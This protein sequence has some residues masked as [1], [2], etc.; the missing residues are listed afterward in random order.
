MKVLCATL[1]AIAG[2][3][4]CARP[5]VESDT[6]SDEAAI[7]ELIAQTAAA[8]NAADT[9]GWVSLFEEGAVYMPPGAPEVTTR[10]GLREM[11]A[12]GFGPYAAAIQITPTEIV[13]LGDWAFARS[14]VTG[15]VTPRTGGDAVTVD[16][17]Q[18]VIYHRQRDGS[19]KIARLINNRNS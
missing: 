10:A 5:G 16:V 7:R 19:W 17:K 14:Q 2:L 4:G 13:I 15:T 8:N 6:A 18:L 9:L 3:T 12:A 1:L 11:A